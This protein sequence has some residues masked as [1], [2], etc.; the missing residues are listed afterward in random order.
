MSS[1]YIQIEVKTYQQDRVVA[2]TIILGRLKTAA[3]QVKEIDEGTGKQKCLAR[4]QA[5]FETLGIRSD[6]YVNKDGYK[7][8]TYPLA[9]IAALPSA[10]IVNQ[11]SGQG[12]YD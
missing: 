1:D 8:Y 12:W 9:Y 10:E 7:D 2:T 4:V 6:F 11:L 3:K 5:Y